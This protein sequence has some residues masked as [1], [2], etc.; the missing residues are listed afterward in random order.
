MYWPWPSTRSLS[1][2]AGRLSTGIKDPWQPS[3]I[4][5]PFFVFEKEN[6]IADGQQRTT[7]AGEQPLQPHS[8]AALGLE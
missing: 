4:A 2:A 8:R 6:I 5:A 7:K 1:R 3:N